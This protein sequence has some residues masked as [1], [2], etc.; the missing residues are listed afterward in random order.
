VPK[1]L[2]SRRREKF[3]RRLSGQEEDSKNAT[4]CCS[5]NA[6][7]HIVKR[8]WKLL[9]EAD[10]VIT[11]NGKKFDSK[12]LNARFIYYDMPPPSPY[13][14]IDTLEAANAA[15]SVGSH[16]LKNM[17]RFLQLPRKMDTD[18]DLWLGCQFGEPGSLKRM[19]EYGLNDTFILEDYYA[20]I[21]AW[22]PK[23][24]N[25]SAYT[26]SYVDLEKGEQSCPVCRSVITESSIDKKYRTTEGYVYDAFRCSCCGAIGRRRERTT[27]QTI[28]VLRAG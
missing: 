9:D 2:F 23:H 20:R 15:F 28:P 22:I 8:I 21:R 26:N 17:M 25:F 27:K 13:H 24:P 5:H 1:Q 14:H 10:V 12:K 6:D 7:L 19:Y 4:V 16:S 11:Q 3:A 18:Y